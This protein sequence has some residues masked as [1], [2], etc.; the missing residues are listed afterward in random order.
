MGS[1]ALRHWH[2]L[3][4][5]SNLCN[6]ENRPKSVIKKA[7][8]PSSTAA[9]DEGPRNKDEGLSTPMPNA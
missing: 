1:F 9:K 5:P 2:L 4:R 6:Q 7:A 3:K 8:L